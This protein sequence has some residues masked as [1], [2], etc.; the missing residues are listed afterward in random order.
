ML[1]R[2]PPKNVYEWL[3]VATRR[4][5]AP[6]KERIEAEIESHYAEAVSARIAQGETERDAYA[7]ALLDLGDARLAGRR[8]R[9]AHLTAFDARRIEAAQKNVGVASLAASYL[10]FGLLLFVSLIE[11]EARPAIHPL[12]LIVETAV[13]MVA[14]PTA[15]LVIA[16]REG[17]TGAR[18]AVLFQVMGHVNRDV[19]QLVL[20]LSVST[21]HSGLY[22]RTPLFLWVL[23]LAFVSLMVS[24]SMGF[25]L[26]RKVS[27]NAVPP[28]ARLSA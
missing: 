8:F 26:W 16:G 10:Y 27:R 3:D 23:V 20:L 13:S 4:L 14:L 6:S 19:F 11:W 7:A 1:W 24:T 2:R 18:L 22:L 5:A 9:R 21:P 12:L 28:P 17:K 15:L 25:A